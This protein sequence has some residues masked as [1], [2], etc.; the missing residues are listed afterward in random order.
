MVIQLNGKQ[1]YQKQ[2]DFWRKEIKLKYCFLTIYSDLL[3]YGLWK[4]IP[5]IQLENDISILLFSTTMYLL[6]IILFTKSM[7]IKLLI[8]SMSNIQRETV[9]E[10][11][12][13]LLLEDV[14][15]FML[16]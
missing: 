13:T 2:V 9:L 7:S 12:F 11:T 10:T 3:K 5:D 8:E 15:L 6:L 14:L 4:V 1:H 16:N